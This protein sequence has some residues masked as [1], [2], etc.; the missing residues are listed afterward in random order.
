MY[1]VTAS[2]ILEL[3]KDNRS[4]LPSFSIVLAI[5]TFFDC[6]LCSSVTL[7]Y[8]HYKDKFCTST[9]SFIISA[10][11]KYQNF[12]LLNNSHVYVSLMYN[13]RRMA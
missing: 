7:L 8:S 13:S 3:S 4:P 1:V 6:S 11:F 2:T 12:N 9:T 5:K 10:I